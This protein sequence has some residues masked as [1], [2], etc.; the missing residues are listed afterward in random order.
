MRPIL[1]LSALA[2]AGALPA[3]AQAPSAGIRLQLPIQCAPGEDC[4]VQNHVDIDPGPGAKDHRCGSNTYEKHNGVDIRVPNLAAQRRGVAVL[5]AADGTVQGVRDGVADVSVAIAGPASVAGRECGNGVSIKHADGYVT[6]YCHMAKGSL[7]V[8]QGEVVKA[9]QSLGLVGMSGLSEYPHVH[10]T[11]WKDGK[12]VDPFAPG[13]APGACSTS[14][15]GQGL[16]DRPIA[17]RAGTVLNAGFADKTLT[18]A[19]VEEGV[20]APTA[21]APMLVAYVRAIN[22]RQGDVQELSLTGPDGAVLAQ[23][24]APALPRAS[25]QRLLFV[26]KRKPASGWAPGAYTATYKV[27]RDGKVAL[28]RTFRQRF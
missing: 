26:G 7:K 3:V 11:V 8:R 1:L 27:R 23:Q 5:A 15:A 21:A 20:A 6:Q 25:A 2:L 14:A 16:W 13:A 4:E 12:V 28:E 10:M 17:Y 18:M 24:T 9:G 22:L 19:D